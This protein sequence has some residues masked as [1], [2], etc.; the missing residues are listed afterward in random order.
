VEANT[1]MPARKD[2]ETTLLPL[3]VDEDFIGDDE[4]YANI[5]S[6]N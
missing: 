1:I 6:K 2:L 4:G 5:S 3:K